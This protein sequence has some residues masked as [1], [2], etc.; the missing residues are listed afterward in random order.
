MSRTAFPIFV[1]PKAISILEKE[2]GKRTLEKHYCQRM[3]I[4]L[5]SNSGKRNMD[6]VNQLS[7]CVDTVMKWKKRWLDN[8]DNLLKLE[9]SYDGKPVSY[10]N[11]IKEYK[12]VLSDM[13]RSGSTGHLTEVDITLL[14][15]LACDPPEKYGLPVTVWTHKL[16][17]TEAKK[18]GIIIS[19]T[20][21]GRILKKMN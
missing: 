8:Q 11:L 1:S 15:A 10:N 13:P 2:V 6:I 17:S 7:I 20:H 4:I 19:S 3:Q 16:L 5:L 9:T 21:Y 14:Q 18:K 12:M